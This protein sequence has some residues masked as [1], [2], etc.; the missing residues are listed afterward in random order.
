MNVRSADSP[1]PHPKTKATQNEGVTLGMRK[2]KYAAAVDIVHH[3]DCAAAPQ[4]TVKMMSCVSIFELWMRIAES[5]FT[6]RSQESE[7][8]DP[9]D[10]LGKR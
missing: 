8:E 9:A 6:K 2:Y 5:Q 3:D 4:A 1:P 10:P 7:S